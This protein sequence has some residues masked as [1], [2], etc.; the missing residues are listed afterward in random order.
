MNKAKELFDQG[1]YTVS[2]VS[3]LVGFRDYSY[4]HKTFSAYFGITPAQ[5]KKN[6]TQKSE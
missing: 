4:F 3:G 2:E 6:A 1:E 5:Y